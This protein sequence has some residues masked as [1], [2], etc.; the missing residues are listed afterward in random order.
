[1]SD[2]ILSARRRLQLSV[3]RA[4]M[5]QEDGTL[6]TPDGLY[7]VRPIL[8][9]G[10]APPVPLPLRS[11]ISLTPRM[12]LVVELGWSK[13]GQREIV[14]P[15]Q[16]GTAS[17][18]INLRVLNP[19]D[20]AASGLVFKETLRELFT[21]AHPSLNGY[22]QVFP[23]RALFGNLV[24]EYA[25]GTI[26][27][28]S[29]KPSAGNHR[30]IMVAL[31]PDGTLTAAASTA[32]ADS[33]GL[34][35]TDLQECRNGLP[36][37]CLPLR[38]LRWDG[39]DSNLDDTRYDPNSN[40][41]GARDMRNL[42]SPV[43]VSGSFAIVRA[44]TTANITLSAPQTIDGVS[45][46]AGDRVLVKNQST[47][48][49]NGL[50]TVQSG[51]WTR[52]EDRIESGMLVSVSEGTAAADT[53]WMLTTNAPIVVGTT[54]LTYAQ[55]DNGLAILKTF[56]NAKGDLIS[57]SAADTPVLLSVGA[58]QQMIIADSAETAGLKWVNRPRTLF[59][60]FADVTVGGSEADIF[61]DTLAAGQ[62]G[63]N[64]DKVNAVW[65]G[66]FVTV[67]T[68][69]TQLQAYFDGQVIWDSTGV[70]PTTGT[71]SWLVVAQ[72]I[73]VSSTVIRYTVSLST[74]GAS[75]YVYCTVGELTGRTLSNTNILK[76][77]GTSSG[78]G[79]GSG[80]IVGKMSTV[81][82][83]PAA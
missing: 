3:D 78:V 76:I 36:A 64:G 67:G 19:A 61:S 59:D 57:A 26:D 27:L 40:P 37:T 30:Y 9:T 23:G 21:Q 71:T 14:G 48:S 74:T 81:E 31:L 56:L 79:S 25:G 66:N 18:G 49:Q 51:A 45:V 38:A 11:G 41:N 12:N 75:G 72:I 73:R 69:L 6:V 52:S 47:A 68:E 8:S 60:H 2:I 65:A 34:D 63:V 77:T 1:M 17:Q 53:L 29:Y 83:I 39:D 80:D 33:S 10:A 20:P 5:G 32:Q 44:A 58:N 16:S 42:W 35:V 24:L 82:F 15:N 22:A 70:A 43:P 54:N 13:T 7:Y 4:Y 46:I 28:S 55:F 62:L 50:Y